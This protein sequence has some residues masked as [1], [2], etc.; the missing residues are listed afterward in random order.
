[1][2]SLVKHPKWLPFAMRAGEGIKGL[3]MTSAMKPLVPLMGY[4]AAH[5]TPLKPSGPERASVSFFEGC[6][7]SAVFPDANQSAKN[8]L[9]RAGL[10]SA[11]PAGQG[12]CGALHLHAG[13]RKA[14][15]QMARKNIEAFENS[16]E[17]GTLIVNTAGGC[18]AMLM[19]YGELLGDDSVWAERARA[20]SARI[21]DWATVFRPLLDQVPLAGTG[22]RVILQNSCHLVNV[23][24]AGD[25]SV[26]LA[27]HVPGD[28][29]IPYQGQD[30]CC[31]SAGIYNIENPQWAVAILDNK[32][33]EVQAVQPDRVLVNNPGCHLQMR[34]GVER[35]GLRETQVQ[36]LAVYLEQSA[37][38][39]GLP[40]TGTASG[41]T[42]AAVGD[43]ADGTAR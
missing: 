17:T 21:R 13:D 41:V 42:P 11:S 27:S 3:P 36:H 32:M 4:R 39:A 1:M 22:L 12:C 6:V 25:D 38:R 9:R 10:T 23:E 37:R 15:Q 5:V 34:W 28:S 24:H 30:Q 2:L 35:A 7:M 33:V 8:L 43:R 20:F 29:L 18:G 16:G 31:G 40:A 14:A 19:E 26:Y